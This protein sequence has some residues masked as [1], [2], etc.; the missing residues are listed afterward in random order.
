MNILDTNHKGGPYENI[1]EYMKRALI[2]STYELEWVYGSRPRDTLQKVDFMNILRSLKQTNKLFSE[3][4]DLD[5]RIHNVR[6]AQS[7]LSDIRC[8]IGGVQNIKKYCKTNSIADIPQVSFLKKESNKDSKNPTLT[9]GQIRNTDYNFRINLK[10]EIDLDESLDE[11]IQFKDNLKS[12]LKYYRYKKRFSFVTPDNLFRIDLTSVKSN[13]Y[14]PKRK[15]Y[16]LAKNLV[17]SRI[18]SG[19]ETYELEI[20]YIGANQTKSGTA[21]EK[22]AEKI[23]VDNKKNVLSD[24]DYAKQVKLCT[25]PTTSSFTPPTGDNNYID[26]DNA[27]YDF[28]S[29]YGGIDDYGGVSEYAIDSDLKVDHDVVQEN[30]STMTTAWSKAAN[31]KGPAMDNIMMNYWA[32]SDKQ[33]LFWGIL[34]NKK[35]LLF[36]GV[37][38][39]FT[40]SYDG[41][42]K[43]E[44]YIKYIIYPPL[45]EEDGDNLSGK[46]KKEFSEAASRGLGF[47]D[48]FYVPFNQVSDLRGP[49]SSQFSS[50][51]NDSDLKNNHLKKDGHLVDTCNLKLNEIL[52]QLLRIIVGKN[53]IVGERKK[54]T[55]LEEYKTLTEQNGK[56]VKFI[57]PQPVSMGLDMLNAD[58]PHSILRGYAVTEKADGIRA[59]LFIDK[60]GS[61]WLI[62]QKKEIIHTGT[63]F[64]N[65]GGPCI[66]DGEYITNDR[67]GRNIDLFMVFDIYYLDNGKYPNHPYTMPWQSKKKGE[68][69]RS[70]IIHDFKSSVSVKAGEIS[71]M[72][73]G[74]YYYKD[75]SENEIQNKDTIRIGYKQYY[76]GPKVLKKDKKDPTKY[77]NEKGICKVSKKILDLDAKDG[78]E[79]TIDGLIYL[80]MY[81]PVGSNSEDI[82]KGDIG[83][84]WFQNYKWKPPEENTIDFRVKFIKE[85]INGKKVNKITSF[86]KDKRTIKCQQVHLY[87]GYDIK[88][89]I[90][91]DFTWKVMSH[92]NRRQTEI[93]FNPP[94]EDDSIHICNIPLYK[95]KMRCSKDMTEVQDGLIYE[96]RF[97]PKNPF[98]SQWSP[99]NVRLDKVRPNNSHTADNVWTT[100][101]YPV[102]EELIRGQTVIERVTDEVVDEVGPKNDKTK[103]YYMEYSEDNDSD[104]PL[105]EFHNYLKDKLINSILGLTTKPVSILDTSVGRGGDI[106]KYLRENSNIAF[107]L[108]MDI[109]PDVNKAAKRFYLTRDTP[110]GLFI[111]YDTSKSISSTGGCVGDHVTRNK[112]LLDILYDRQKALPKE[113]RTLV[114]K[115]KGLAKKGFD[116]ISSQFTIHYYF[117]DE[118]TLRSYIQNISE[119]LKKGGHFIGTCYDGMKVFQRLQ[120]KSEQDG[121]LEMID[122]FGNIVYSITKNYEIDDFTYKRDDTSNL[123]GQ[124]INVYMSSIGKAF[125]EYLVNFEYFIEIMKEYDLE[126]ATPKFKQNILFGQ[127]DMT[128]TSGFGGFEQII[129]E[130]DK[131]YS[132]DLSLKQYY[133]EAFGLMKPKN[134]LLRELS[135]FNNWFIFEKKS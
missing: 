106:G 10:K 111:Q 7:R 8:T 135:S 6:L 23:L 78:Y 51:D 22:F 112:L 37:Q 86:T 132:K 58:N 61:G 70:S 91:T 32:D 92:D 60:S 53:I 29:D 55:I 130:L 126:L 80:P 96:M 90:T 84:T 121:Q 108:G 102:T 88:R 67:K 1:K 73:D 72:R 81:Y 65:I 117:S 85:E 118:L 113:L 34:N 40:D 99:L 45:L 56:D 5:I 42:P 63:V 9:F 48:S 39:N 123:L 115:Y 20:E 77:T 125:P 12:S 74:V 66:L 30:K 47:G 27:G 127:K 110:K 54:Q 2:D 59:E 107:F 83:E 82:V 124:E 62:T 128:Y 101:K 17:D 109:S 18:L 75:G 119:N 94:S 98:G 21:I 114:P 19:K 11:V 13:T 129:G 49:V 15:T 64:S 71:S 104:K 89:D 33:W 87:V 120:D 131:L 41:A 57:G 4:N 100:I 50:I 16:N 76:E 44:T 31:L 69:C 24:E 105:R 116:L 68:L 52:S 97:D 14:N 36:D 28:M 133:P 38:E 35:Q 95:D 122:E 26:D 46:F 25:T 79:Y 103:G 93:L 3:T 134:K 43:N